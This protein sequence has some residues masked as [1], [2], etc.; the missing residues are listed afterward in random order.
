MFAC[1][2]TKDVYNC[3]LVC[4][5]WN[6]LANSNK[7]WRRLY[8][9]ELYISNIL[10]KSET[11]NR[12]NKEHKEWKIIFRER[13]DQLKQKFSHAKIKVVGNKI[14]DPDIGASREERING[15][16]KFVEQL[17]SNSVIRGAIWA[18]THPGNRDGNLWAWS[19]NTDNEIS[20]ADKEKIVKWLDDEKED[21]KE[22]EI[23]KFGQ[24]THKVTL[25]KSTEF[26]VSTLCRVM[27][28][29]VTYSDN[30]TEVFTFWR[31]HNCVIFAV[32]A[33]TS[34]TAAMDNCKYISEYIFDCGY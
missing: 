28:G 10:S 14:V 12:L 5:E 17:Q 3:A 27:G 20:F 15:W 4:R 33:D 11:V 32:F 31:C 19:T 8:L 25:R 2:T 6:L 7:I 26:S 24:G 30:T 29:R 13:K 23:E 22:I 1:V 18:G 16:Q 9:D 21:D 34:F